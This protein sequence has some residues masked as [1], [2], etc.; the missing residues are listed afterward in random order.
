MIAF[1]SKLIYHQKLAILKQN[2]NFDLSKIENLNHSLL[3]ILN[4]HNKNKLIWANHLELIPWFVKNKYFNWV[5]LF[6][7][8]FDI[9]KILLLNFLWL[10]IQIIPSEN[11]L[12]VLFIIRRFFFSVISA[13]I[14]FWFKSSN[15]RPTAENERGPNY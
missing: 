13:R 1:P 8:I 6:V 9:N 3:F 2:L 10:F 14:K 15:E 7:I 5:W 12:M 4:S 11:N